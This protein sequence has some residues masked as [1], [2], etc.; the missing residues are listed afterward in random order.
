M[1][2]YQLV[3]HRIAAD[4]AHQQGNDLPDRYVEWIDIDALATAVGD[5]LIDLAGTGQLLAS[6]NRIAR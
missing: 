6:M 1:D 2:L 5:L 3:S 4:L